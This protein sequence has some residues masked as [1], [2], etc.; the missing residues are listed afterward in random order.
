[1]FQRLWSG[2]VVHE[3]IAWELL[4]LIDQI[5]LWAITEYRTFV[6]EHLRPWH[7]LCQ[8]NYLFEWDSMYDLGEHLKRKRVCHE[9][10]DL[11]APS[12][13]GHMNEPSRRTFQ[14]RAKLSLAEAIEEHSLIKG[15]APCRDEAN[16]E[17]TCLMSG[18]SAILGSDAAF[19][20]HMRRAHVKEES[21]MAKLRWCI[22]ERKIQETIRRRQESGI[23][24]TRHWWPGYSK[25]HRS[26]E[27]DEQIKDPGLD[28]RSKRIKVS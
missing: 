10:E 18:C 20:D 11:M 27:Q 19:L 6:L 9:T 24:A 28:G 13:V 12:W 2:H 25:R 4:S 16:R 8:E 7:R 26:P 3:E 5:H 17:W 22:E 23:R 14:R 15:K 21:Q 1:M